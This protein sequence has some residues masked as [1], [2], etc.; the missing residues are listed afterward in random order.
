MA[1]PA[2]GAGAY[3]V[4][5]D[6]PAGHQV[7]DRLA[8]LLGIPAGAVLLQECIK[9]LIITTNLPFNEWGKFFTDEQ[10]AAA[11]IAEG[12]FYIEG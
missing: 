6:A 2:H 9:A 8:Q 12:T 3:T 5:V 11:I 4:G 7:L 1:V 10:L